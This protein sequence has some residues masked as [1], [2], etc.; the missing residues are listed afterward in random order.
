MEW[1]GY[2]D[3]ER[4]CLSVGVAFLHLEEYD[5]SF[6]YLNKATE[7]DSLMPFSYYFRAKI[8]YIEDYYNAALQFVKSCKK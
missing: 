5:S 4:N 7:I 2:T 6:A 3:D 8:N 1:W